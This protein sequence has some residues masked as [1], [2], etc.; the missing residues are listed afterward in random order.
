MGNEVKEKPEAS[1]ASIGLVRRPKWIRRL[2]F[3]TFLP[4]LIPL[5]VFYWV[6]QLISWLGWKCEKVETWMDSNIHFDF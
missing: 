5:C 1:V 2:R 6:M 3:I 4:V